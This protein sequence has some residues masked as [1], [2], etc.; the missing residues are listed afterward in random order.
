MTR[1]E[2]GHFTSQRRSGRRRRW[3]RAKR[4]IQGVNILGERAPEDVEEFF[5]EAQVAV[6]CSG[7]EGFLFNIL[8]RRAFGPNRKI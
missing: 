6:S 4:C 2:T 5:H 3:A 8:F 1:A 7:G